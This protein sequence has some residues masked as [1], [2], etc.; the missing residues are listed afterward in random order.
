MASAHS[1][2]M[3]LAPVQGF[4]RDEQTNAYA[5]ANDLA[6]AQE[7][8]VIVA[9]LTLDTARADL[10]VL[11]EWLC[12]CEEARL[13]NLGS[14]PAEICNEIALSPVATAALRQASVHETRSIT[15]IQDAIF[16]AEACV[17]R[18]MR[19]ILGQVVEDEDVDD[20]TGYS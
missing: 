11:D 9:R 19:S 5:R 13:E 16:E 15:P 10:D 2:A 7:A 18:R 3:H 20:S 14:L 6:R 1:L 17:M 12:I 4:L 8:R